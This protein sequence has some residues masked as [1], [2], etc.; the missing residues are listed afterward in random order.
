MIATRTG[1]DDG[2]PSAEMTGTPTVSPPP[3]PPEPGD[4][5]LEQVTGV[6]VA[7]GDA[8]LVVTWTA[9]DDATG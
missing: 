3:P 6:G 2:P 7:P 1:A 9:V 5:D 8:Q 4:G